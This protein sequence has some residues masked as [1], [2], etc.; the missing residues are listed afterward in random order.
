MQLLWSK[1]A[2]DVW[3][4]LDTV[5]LDHPRFDNVEGVYVIWHGGENAATVRVGQGMIRDRLRAHREDAQVQAY[6]GLGLYVSWAAVP[7]M[8]RDGVEEYL[9]QRLAPMLG[10]R[11]PAWTPVQVNLPW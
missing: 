7:R 9:T 11:S 3:C 1:C 2:G 4:R 8:Y 5:N 10:K 6:A